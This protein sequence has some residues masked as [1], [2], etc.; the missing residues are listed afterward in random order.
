MTSSIVRHL[1]LKDLHLLRW[2]AGGFGRP[3]GRVDA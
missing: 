2:I 3:R 1:I